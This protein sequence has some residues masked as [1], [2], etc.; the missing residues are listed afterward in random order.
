[1]WLPE[2]P[3]QLKCTYPNTSMISLFKK[4]HEG[5]RSF[6]EKT[7]NPNLYAFSLEL[8]IVAGIFLGISLWQRD[9]R[10]AQADKVII[11][12]E[13]PRNLNP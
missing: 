3:L 12:Q 4:W 5:F 8:G 13:Q 2:L 10:Q 6:F 9:Y 7:N 11:Q 1:M